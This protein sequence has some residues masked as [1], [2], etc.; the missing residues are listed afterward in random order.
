MGTISNTVLQR[1][2]RFQQKQKTI[3]EL[4]QPEW[5]NA[6]DY[7]PERDQKYGTSELRVPAV[8]K[9]H[10]NDH[11]AEPAATTFGDLMECIEIV[12]GISRIPQ[13]TSS[14]GSGHIWLGLGKPQ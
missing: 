3:D 14:P 5:G 2:E 12:P 9:L 11:V 1:M 7:F 6:P 4:T 13:G 10:T 8:V